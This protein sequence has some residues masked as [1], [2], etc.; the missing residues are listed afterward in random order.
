MLT[1]DGPRLLECNVRLGDPETQV[2]L[3]RLAAPLGPLLLAAARGPLADATRPARVPALPRRGGRRSSSRRRAIPATPQPRRRR[4]TGS[5]TAAA[6][7]ALVFHAGDAAATPAAAAGRP[8][9]GS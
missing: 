7:G 1:A 8:A 9:A 4:S 3:P 6:A 5:T 2:I